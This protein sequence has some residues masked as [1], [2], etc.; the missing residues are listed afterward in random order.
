MNEVEGVDENLYGFNAY[1]NPTNGTLTLS[2]IGAS[3]FVYCVYNL[4]GQ[5]VMNGNAHGSETHLDLNGLDKGL[6]FVSIEW[7]CG[8]L[9]QKVIV[10]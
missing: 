1:P 6:Y 4:T 9:I 5:C 10:R 2:L 7:N 3:D 8:R